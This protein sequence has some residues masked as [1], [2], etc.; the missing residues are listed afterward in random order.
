MKHRHT[1]QELP[2]EDRD[3]KS[4]VGLAWFGCGLAVLTILL[5]IFAAGVVL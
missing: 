3:F 2:P 1:F 4:E 5:F